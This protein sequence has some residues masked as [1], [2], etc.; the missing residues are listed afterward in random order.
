MA[1]L[2]DRL[3]GLLHG[4]P[5]RWLVAVVAFSVAAVVQTWPLVKHI[6]SGIADGPSSWNSIADTYAF[7]WNLWW[8]KHALID[9]HTNPYHTDL[10]YFPQG[11]NLYLHTMATV[12]GVMSIPLQLLTGN[13]FLSWNILALLLF[14]FSG[15]AMYALSYKVNG[16]HVGALI[17]GYLFAFFPLVMIHFN[18]HWHISTVWFM[19]VFALF[20]V[21]L[22]EIGRFR[23]A[24]AAGVVWALL[25][26]NNL[27]YSIDAGIFLTLFVGYWSFVYL[28]R[29]DRVQFMTFLRGSILVGLVWFVITAP[30]LIFTLRDINSGEYYMPG[31]D[32]YWS[33]D[34]VS[35]VTPSKLWGEGTDPPA[36][37]PGVEHVPIGAFE[38]TV[39]LTITG[40]ILASLAVLTCRRNPH[41]VL[42]WG[43]FVVFFG[44]M[45]LGP[46]L[47]IGGTKHFSLLGVSF[48]VPM[49]YQLIDDVPVIGGR[50]SSTRMVMFGVVGYC[51]LVGAGFTF[52]MDWLRE[53]FRGPARIL[54]PLVSVLLCGLVVLEFWNPP[55]HVSELARP[56]VFKRIGDEPGDFSVLHA[57]WGRLTG[58][59]VVGDFYA[60]FLTNYDQT[61]YEKPSFGGLLSR[62][63]EPTLAWTGHEPGLHYL[64]CL[65][66]EK[67]DDMDP[68]LVR[69]VF[70]R[71]R[72]KYVI[73]DKIDPH[74][75][76]NPIPGRDPNQLQTIEAYLREVAGL[77]LFTEEP[78]FTIYRNPTIE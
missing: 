54:A 50:R 4:G 18:N 65:C 5:G 66:P 45:S 28:R 27:E 64:A 31:N 39:Y 8:V 60:G 77:T 29:R 30:L 46:Y 74:G 51:V 25:T 43:M 11:S 72:I 42:F 57:P 53:H 61:L 3:N 32:E 16:N 10:L 12:N 36:D 38:N 23:E 13:L 2:R 1:A 44:V 56:A 76:A 41:R 52:L 21:R 49:P 34:L 26:Y 17:S 35:F 24:V 6:S 20:L 48:T 73:I 14:V 19:P 15:L 58:W 9:L 7:I 59:G 33:A 75:P 69:E 70:Q 40:I 62:A 37:P 63:R 71:Y 22:Q 47:Y 68:I 78:N 55:L 67:P